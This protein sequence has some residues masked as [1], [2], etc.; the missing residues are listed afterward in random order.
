MRLVVALFVALGLILGAVLVVPRLFQPAPAAER[1]AGVSV[2]IVR[3]AMTEPEPDRH[4]LELDIEIASPTDLDVCM[5]FALDQAFASRRLEAQSSGGCVQPRAGSQVVALALDDLSD[6]DVQLP[7]HS[8]VWGVA[9]GRCGPVFE[10]IG[11]CV[12]EVV[13]TIAFELPHDPVLPTFGPLGS[14]FPIFSFS[15]P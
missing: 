7:S 8:L 14:F 15:L 9:G 4:A 5:G 1:L 6:T 11:V 13:D 12:V 2:S 10:L 3:F